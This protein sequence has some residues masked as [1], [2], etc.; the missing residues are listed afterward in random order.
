MLHLTIALFHAPQILCDGQAHRGIHEILLTANF[1]KSYVL[2]AL[3]ISNTTQFRKFSQG[4]SPFVKI[5]NMVLSHSQ[6]PHPHPM[7]SLKAV[8]EANGPSHHELSP[9]LAQNS[10]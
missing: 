7:S 8:G 2:S 10:K 3:I 6:H 1:F 9:V 4:C 5:S